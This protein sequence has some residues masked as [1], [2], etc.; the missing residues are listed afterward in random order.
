[1]TRMVWDESGLLTHYISDRLET[2]F[3][4]RRG[5]FIFFDG[6]EMIGAVCIYDERKDGDSY[7]LSI[8]GVSDSPKW[9]TRRNVSDMSSMFFEK[10]PYGMGVTRLN[11]FIQMD[12][13]HSIEITK[14]IGFKEEGIM[15]RAGPDGQD[16]MVLGM[17]P[18][19]C[20]WLRSRGRPAKEG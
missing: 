13:T 11:S 19:D 1:M 12:N 4:P 9:F 7:Q 15:R 14:R 3:S 5:G 18:E 2:K 20:I 16:V 17:L 6:D 8:A 10:P